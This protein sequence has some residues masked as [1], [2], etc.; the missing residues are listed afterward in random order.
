MP[1]PTLIATP[2]AADANSYCTLA[3]AN[4]YHD[5]HLYAT[6]WTG[7]ASDDVRT[8]ALIMATRLIDQHIDWDGAKTS[9]T[10]ALRWPRTGMEDGDGY[11]IDSD[12]IPQLL[13]DATAELAR[14]LIGSDLTTT[15]SSGGEINSIKVGPIAIGYAEGVTAEVVTIPDSVFFMLRQWGTVRGRANGAIPLY[16]V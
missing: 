10:Q 16:R 12:V 11:S 1:V 9:E 7:A 6:T 13:K 14:L 8:V 2:G 4:T 3:E 5:A 15:S